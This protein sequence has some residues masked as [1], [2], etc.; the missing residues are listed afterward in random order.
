MSD[1]VMFHGSF[2]SG[3]TYRWVSIIGTSATIYAHPKFCWRD[4]MS[5]PETIDIPTRKLLQ[6]VNGNYPFKDSK[7][8]PITLTKIIKAVYKKK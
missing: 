3:S 6:F 1:D 7:F 2:G 5:C 8:E 4:R